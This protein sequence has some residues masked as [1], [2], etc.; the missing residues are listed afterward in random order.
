[1]VI[2]LCDTERKSHRV[3]IAIKFLTAV[4]ELRHK[5]EMKQLDLK[6]LFLV[7]SGRQMLDRWFL[8]YYNDL[9]KPLNIFNKGK[10]VVISNY[11][12]HP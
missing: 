11:T 4:K 3:A 8:G 7:S 1:M 6:F 12:G 5:L 10:C 2:V 9:N